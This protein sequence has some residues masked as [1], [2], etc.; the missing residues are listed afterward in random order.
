LNS[1]MFLCVDIHGMEKT[2]EIVFQWCNNV[3]G[4]SFFFKLKRQGNQIEGS[5][6]WTY[7]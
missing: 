3:K 2:R 6:I 4:R 5:F 1:G 7:F